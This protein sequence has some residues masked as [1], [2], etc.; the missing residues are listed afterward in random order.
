M[1]PDPPIPAPARAPVPVPRRAAP[2][3]A[4]TATLA[5]LAVVTA[6]LAAAVTRGVP[7]GRDLA[8]H[9]ALLA[10]FALLVAWL[11]RR[12]AWR[13]TPHLRGAAIIA[14]MFT[15]YTTLGHVAF[16]AVP[17]LADGAL[18]AADRALLLGRSPAMLVDGAVGPRGTE[19]LAFFYAAYIPYLYMTIL[20]GLVGRPA[21]ER[22]AFVTGFALLYLFAFLG[23]LFVPARGPIVHLAGDFA[24]PLR[25]GTFHR[26]VVASID[27]M[28]GPHGAFP[29]LHVGASFFAAWF[30]WRH[31]SRLRALIYVP[32][33][34]LI[35][36]ATIVLRY[37]WVV[38]LAAGV[39][40]A[41]LA[42]H[43]APRLL[44]RWRA[45]GAAA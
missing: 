27:R 44:A 23:Y 25:G 18:D 38:D 8:V 37:H 7:L 35:A 28:G 30:D 4:E 11:G 39:V 45:R 43:L 13:W 2:H 31:G 42:G 12:A 6:T 29:S 15:L 33:V 21:E 26:M 20:L 9:A 5:I 10:A 16:D 14:V 32:L 22:D 3:P 41:L 36:V 1:P 17:W 34:A 19:L 24:A 40:L